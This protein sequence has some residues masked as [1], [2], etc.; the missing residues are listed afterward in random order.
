MALLSGYTP[1]PTEVMDAVVF[2]KPGASDVLKV[3]SDITIHKCS[4]VPVR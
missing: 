4:V 3:I 1:I 2:D